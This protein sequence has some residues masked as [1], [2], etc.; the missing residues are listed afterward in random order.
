MYSLSKS[1]QAKFYF[2]LK[3]KVRMLNRV[4]RIKYFCLSK[5]YSAEKYYSDSEGY[6][7]GEMNHG[8]LN[9]SRDQVFKMSQ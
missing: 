6:L 5:Y 1:R 7:T 9:K 2:L 3:T 8:I 4:I